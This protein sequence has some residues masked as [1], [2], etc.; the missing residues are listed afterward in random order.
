MRGH[1]GTRS[2][3][4]LQWITPLGS[5]PWGSRIQRNPAYTKEYIARDVSI[6]DRSSVL[7]SIQ[8]FTP[9]SNLP[10]HVTFRVTPS[11]YSSLI[12]YPTTQGFVTVRLLKYM[13]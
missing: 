2:R 13:Y 12:V 4:G 5:D 9:A 10:L 6:V 8:Q 3:D 11:H 7:N 1:H